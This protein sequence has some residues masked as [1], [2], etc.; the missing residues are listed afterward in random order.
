VWAQS[1]PPGNIAITWATQPKKFVL[2]KC[3]IL[4]NT[5]NRFTKMS[6]E[7][8]PEQ[9]TELTSTDNVEEIE[10]LNTEETCPSPEIIQD[11]RFGF[12]SLNDDF[13]SND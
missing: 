4:K 10:N 5:K 1:S 8:I 6:G 2:R 7:H 3:A 12:P 9:V 11:H 13:R